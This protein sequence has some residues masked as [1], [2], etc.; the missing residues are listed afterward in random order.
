MNVRLNIPRARLGLMVSIGVMSLCAS[1][2]VMADNAADVRT[3]GQSAKGDNALETV[4]VTGSRTESR[5]VAQSLAPIDV[6][7]ADDLARSGKQN[8]RDALAAQVPSYTNDA[9]FTGASGIAVK[10]ATLRGLGGNAVLVLVNGKRRHNTAQIF[11]Q[12]SST[13]NG[14]SPVDLDLIPLSAVDHIEVLRDGAAAQYGSDAIAGVINIIL[15][16]NKSGGQATALYGQYGQREGHKGNFGATGES[17]VNQGFELPNDGFFTI[18]GDIKVQETSNTAGAVPDRTKIYSGN[19][20]REF[21]ESRNRQ[22]MGQPRAQ[23]YNFAYNA[24]L[25][26]NDALDFYSFST[27]S[28]RDSTG[29]GTYRT[30]NSA[31]NIPEIYPDGFLPKFRSVEDDLQGVFGLKGKDALGWDWDLSTSY[32]RNDV[33]YHNDDS[34]NASFGPAS[35][36]NIDNGEA[37]FSQW[38]NNLDINRSFDTGLFASPLHVAGG[39]EYRVD[40]YQIR[41]GEFASY[42]D[43][44]YI[45]PVGS[46]NAGKR[47]NSGSAGWGGF[48]PEAAGSWDRSNTAGY[49]DFTQKLTNDWEL[50]LAGRFEHYSD[51]GDTTSGK[52]STRYQLT[53]TFAVRGAINNGFRA[54]SLQ[55]QYF[56]SSTSAWSANPVTGVLSQTVTTYAQPG[57]ATAAALGSRKLKPESSRNYSVGFVA[58]PAKNLDVTVDLY[59]ID[60]KDRI[61]QTSALSGVNDPA[62]AQLLAGAGL[63]TNQSVAYYG[64]LADTRTR[65][66]DLVAD[67]RT[68]YGAYGRGKWTLTSTQSLQEIRG[69]KQPDSLAGTNVQVLGRDKQGNLTSAFPKNKTALSHTWF[70]DDFEVAI[71]ETRYSPVT[72]KNYYNANRDEKIKS[73]FITDLD[74]AYNINDQFRV[75]VGGLNIFNERP[76]QISEQAKLYYFMPVDNPAYSWY[77][78]YGVDGGYYYARLD[79]FW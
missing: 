14:Q 22:I 1:A 45:Y 8:L 19:D 42:A 29:F 68:Q 67:Y 17:L 10:S 63:S 21:G 55:Q 13:S 34:L 44:G 69:I 20:P 77:S 7:S 71:K 37:I 79:Y 72:G 43:G 47:P 52:L 24:E 78:P 38:T 66:I 76:E 28:H 59:Q 36:T 40:G 39:I 27:F 2:S 61:L 50:S 46:P 33:N 6:I 62:I 26:L 15:K 3:A 65:G 54:P 18:S 9:G 25:P 53:P 51:V 56:S 74:V 4:V 48:S 41:K 60:I 64:N 49:V 5:T 58:T 23:T 32:G 16:R 30:A 31:Q 57:S 75:S 12:S 35:P 11:H 70:I 73:A